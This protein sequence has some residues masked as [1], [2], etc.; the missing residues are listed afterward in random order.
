[1]KSGMTITNKLLLSFGVAM[2]LTLGACFLAFGIAGSLGGTVG[3]LANVSARRLTLAGD[4]DL[5]ITEQ[6]SAERA[7]LVR[8]YMK[9]T[10]AMAKYN[11]EFGESAARAAKDLDELVPLLETDEGR[12]LV[13]ELKGTVA[14]VAQIHVAVWPL[15][16]SEKPDQAAK[17]YVENLSAVLQGKA[18]AHRLVDLQSRLTAALTSE[19]EASVSQDRWLMSLIIVLALGVAVV[20]VF[21]VRRI[22]LDLRRLV[23]DLSDGAE[24]TASAAAQVASS[25]QS[26]AQGASEQ[27]ATLEETS[28]SSSEVNSMARRNTENSRS[29]A[30]LVTQSQEKF[31]QTDHALGEMQTAMDEINASSDKISKIIKVIDEISFQTNI[32]ALNAAVEAARAGEAGMG[33]AVVADEVRNLAQRCAQ[34]ARDTA[35]LIEESITKSSDGKKKVDHVATAIHA[36]TAESMKVKT[37]VDEVSSGSQEQAR[38][39]QQIGAAITQMERV[40]Q[41]NAASAEESAA[42]AQ[43]LTAQSAALRGVVE[44]LTSMVGGGEI[45]AA[46]KAGPA[47]R[48]TIATAPRKN[49]AAVAQPENFPMEGDLNN[50]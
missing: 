39:I 6:I 44:R 21:V 10:A 30:D 43:E 34:A 33:F 12:R 29:A 11:Q 4:L 41:T 16:S 40:T 1:M 42:A 18:N 50:F 22:S 46:R 32:L 47:P 31:G 9:D 8:A 37:L 2:A 45:A 24:Q 38:G 14:K 15:A 49:I 48:T 17:A 28:A 23:S 5:A 7:I 26:L 13:E 35:A 25:S 3:K 27:A 36:I 20:V 19:T